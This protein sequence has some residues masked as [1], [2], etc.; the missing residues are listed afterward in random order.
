MVSQDGFACFGFEITDL[1]LLSS[2]ATYGKSSIVNQH[3]NLQID[4]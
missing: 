4:A 1:C 3:Q 2:P